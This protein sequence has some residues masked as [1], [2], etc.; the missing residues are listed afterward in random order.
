[1]NGVRT[2]QRDNRWIKTAAW[3]LYDIQ[4]RWEIDS[5]RRFSELLNI[6]P[7]TMAKLNPKHPDGTLRLLTLDKIFKNLINLLDLLFPVS[8]KEEERN[9]I[10]KARFRIIDTENPSNPTITAARLDELKQGCI[11]VLK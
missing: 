11:E 9:L 10:M 2:E 5:T 8:M 4:M 6:S 7:H 1:M 3:E